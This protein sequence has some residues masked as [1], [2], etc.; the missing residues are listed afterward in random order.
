VL[1]LP[2]VALPA[3]VD[4]VRLPLGVQLVGRRWGDDALL[5]LGL[6]AQAALPAAVRPW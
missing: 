6:W 2:V 4:D 1:G 5:A 3:G